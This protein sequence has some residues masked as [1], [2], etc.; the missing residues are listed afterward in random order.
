MLQQF[1]N[2]Y[3][4]PAGIF[5]HGLIGLSR[6]YEQINVTVH[7]MIDKQLANPLDVKLVKRPL[8]ECPK[9]LEIQFP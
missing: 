7:I 1:A 5:N 3:T 9:I 6:G 8:K 2:L 4:K